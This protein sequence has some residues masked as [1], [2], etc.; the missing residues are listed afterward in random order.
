MLKPL[1]VGLA[2]ITLA[3]FAAP[4]T[5]NLTAAESLPE[6]I[7]ISTPFQF[8]E[9]FTGR[10]SVNPFSRTDCSGYSDVP[11]APLSTE[12]I[13]R[14]SAGQ[15]VILRDFNMAYE[16]IR[17]PF[18]FE[19]GKLIIDGGTYTTLGSCFIHLSY[20]DDTDETNADGLTI[21][22]GD[23]IAEGGLNRYSDS[24]LCLNFL[25]HYDSTQTENI[26]S[27]I[28][29][30]DSYYSEFGTTTEL[31][32]AENLA[33][34]IEN[35]GKLYSETIEI[36]KINRTKFSVRKRTRSVVPTQEPEPESTPSDE[37]AEEPSHESPVLP[38]APNSAIGRSA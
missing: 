4:I 20:R 15:T 7:V 22:A 28:L 23:F 32:L 11:G 14:I 37:P 27:Q 31:P 26:F 9:Y 36:G 10:A 33:G 21:L 3:S 12:G 30:P 8:C 6:P 18:I 17:F 2:A 25:N 35:I 5:T 24:P 13:F 29:G 19:G 16:S 1:F 34:D 38:K